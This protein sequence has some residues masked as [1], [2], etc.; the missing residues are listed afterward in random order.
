MIAVRDK[1]LDASDDEVSDEDGYL[2]RSMTIE[3]YNKL[4]KG[5]CIDEAY[6]DSQH[7][8]VH[9]PLTPEIKRSHQ[10]SVLDA[11]DEGFHRQGTAHE[12]A[13]E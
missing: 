5:V 2:S 9:V 10:H 12:G 6:R 11:R 8:T 1:F 13:E 7:V 4:V 3:A